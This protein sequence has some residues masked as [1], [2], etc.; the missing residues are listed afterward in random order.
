MFGA[1]LLEE[2]VYRHCPSGNGWLGFRHF[3]T[4]IN[5]RLARPTRAI[6]LDDIITEQI[7]IPNDQRAGG[8][9]IGKFSSDFFFGFVTVITGASDLYGKDRCAFQK[10]HAGRFPRMKRGVGAKRFT[11]GKIYFE[12]C[13]I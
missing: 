6:Y 10:L 9:I 13:I 4:P 1:A 8:K 11:A 3:T 5:H 2:V 7:Y 12:S